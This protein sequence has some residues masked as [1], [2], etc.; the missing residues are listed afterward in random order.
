M[1]LKL[2][3]A[4]NVRGYREKSEWTQEKLAAKSGLNS[5]YLSRL[6]GGKK[7]PSVETIEKIA[8]A[9]KIEPSELLVKQSY[10]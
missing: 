5:E 7:N 8:K 3:V 1:K 10:K 2:I 9:F 4:D 6:E